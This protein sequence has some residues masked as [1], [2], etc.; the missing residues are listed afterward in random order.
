MKKSLSLSN[1]AELVTE[2]MYN[3]SIPEQT[4]VLKHNFGI[5]VEDTDDGVV[6]EGELIS[7]SKFD[8]N[9]ME[10]LEHDLGPNEIVALWESYVNTTCELDK[11][12]NVTWWEEE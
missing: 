8:V 1:I 9:F 12:N 3:M 11:D 4:E 10:L 5:S 7:D 6:W 2:R